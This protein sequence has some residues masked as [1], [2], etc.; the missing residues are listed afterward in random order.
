MRRWRG[1]ALAVSLVVC[2]GLLGCRSRTKQE[3]LSLFFDGVPKAGQTTASAVASAEPAQS[4]SN[5]IP[6][7]VAQVLAAS[8]APKMN[9]HPPFAD[10]KCRECHIGGLSQSLKEKPP[11]LCFECHEDFLAKAKVKHAPVENGE[12]VACHAPHESTNK[13]LLARVGKELCFECHDDFLAKAKVKHQ[14]AE[15]GECLGCHSPHTSTN[16]F[17]L[18]RTGK[19]LCFE[20]HDDFLAKA[21]FKHSAV[22]NCSDCHKPHQGEDRYFL[23]KDRQVLCFECH[24]QKEMAALKGHAKTN[25]TDC[26]LC[27]DPHA[28]GNKA[29][30]KP[31]APKQAPSR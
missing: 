14:P 19:A 13:F 6:A 16:K 10:R 28:E 20:C 2:A 8:S 25:S 27:H 5:A 26:L 30:L 12:C 23:V 29:L 11:K 31:Q 3:W 7:A 18:A 21:A 15:N 17:L 22:D 24:D 9:V 4:G 1:S